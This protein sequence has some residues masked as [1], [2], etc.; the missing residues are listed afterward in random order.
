MPAVEVEEAENPDDERRRSEDDGGGREKG[1]E[2][3]A[4][5]RVTSLDQ[6]EALPLLSARA[7]SM[8]TRTR[9]KSSSVSAETSA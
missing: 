5:C 3:E 9:S 1:E 2:A 4:V 6:T 8:E 7:E